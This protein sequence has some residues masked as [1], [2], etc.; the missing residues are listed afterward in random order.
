MLLVECKN[1]GTQ[2]FTE[3]NADPDS[4]LAC[5]EGSGCCAEDHHHGQAANET[6]TPCRPVTI[7]VLPGS[8]K[9]TMA[10]G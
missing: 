6:G 10:G 5:V 1:C 4:A 3:N 7:T 8:V 2:A 9:M